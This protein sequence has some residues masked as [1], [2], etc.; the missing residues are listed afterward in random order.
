M[1]IVDIPPGLVPIPILNV[2]LSLIDKTSNIPLYPKFDVPD[3]LF[4]DLTLLTWIVCP[5]FSL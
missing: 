2:F 5:L 1:V 4:V 3:V